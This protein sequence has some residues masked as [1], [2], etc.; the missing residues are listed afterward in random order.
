MNDEALEGNMKRVF[1]FIKES[2]GCHLRKI[3]RELAISMGTAQYHLGKLEKMRKIVSQR[4]GLRKH[5]FVLGV[6][7]QEER[8]L[9]Q[10]LGNETAREILMFIGEQAD[11][12]QTDIVE[13]IG[14]SQPSVNWHIRR[15]S[16]LGIIEQARE[17]KFKRFK[18]RGDSKHI[19]ALLRSYYPSVWN[20]WSSKLA[21]TFLALSRDGS[22]PA[23]QTEEEPE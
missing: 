10:V 11:P 21:E 3:K 9:L 23:E 12:T 20:R 1:Q 6:F 8:A 19:V 14:I 15:L 17:G 16:G 5:Y 2:P 7:G 22:Q 13:R 18:L 4:H